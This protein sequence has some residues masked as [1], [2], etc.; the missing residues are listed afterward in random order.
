LSR[1]IP[2]GVPPEREKQMQLFAAGFG[3]QGM[4]RSTRIPN[5]RRALALAEFARDQGKLDIFRSLAMEAYWKE[6]ND[7]EDSAILRNLAIAS[8]LDPLKA[9]AAAD[10][11]VYLG[12]V[13]TLRLEANQ[14][15]ITGIPTFIFKTERIVGCQPYEIVAAAARR[16]GAYLK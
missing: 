9:L 6:G 3:I 7:I 12:R 4:K 8:G 2:G 11:P 1:L 15:Q 5:T 16:A 10:D 14:L 13:D